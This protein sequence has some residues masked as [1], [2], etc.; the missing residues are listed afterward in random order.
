M[1]FVSFNSYTTGVTCGEGTANP[2]GA[3]AFIPVLSRVRVARSLVFCVVF[4][5]SLFVLFLC[6]FSFGLSIYSDY[7]V[8]F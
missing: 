3:P 6:P 5:R 2:F 7:P 8:V 1:N 4:C